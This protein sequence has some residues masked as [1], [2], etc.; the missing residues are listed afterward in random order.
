M[1]QCPN[2]SRHRGGLLTYVGGR[3][4]IE[5]CHAV[6]GEELPGLLLP[7][8]RP[9]KSVILAEGGGQ[10]HAPTRPLFLSFWEDQI[11]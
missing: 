10:G 4:V 3:G 7:I 9:A 5:V 6:R 11:S 1:T 8:G 2:I